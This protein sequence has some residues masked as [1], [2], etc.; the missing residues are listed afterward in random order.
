MK[1]SKKKVQKIR[2]L[3]LKIVK[4]ASI[5]NKQRLEKI[6]RYRNRLRWP[7]SSNK[8]LNFSRSTR[9]RKRF[10]GQFCPKGTKLEVP[11]KSQFQD[12][13]YYGLMND[14]DIIKR[15]KLVEQYT[16]AG[17]MNNLVKFAIQ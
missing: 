2:V 5:Q 14:E 17:D 12:F 11:S 9:Q 10:N 6:Q 4:L 7:K 13:G 8:A 16:K 3:I 15:N 1:K